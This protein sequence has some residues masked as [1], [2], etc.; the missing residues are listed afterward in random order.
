MSDYSFGWLPDY[1]DMRDRSVTYMEP[2]D[3]PVI[4]PKEKVSVH[5]LWA[6]ASAVSKK[7]AL[8]NLPKKVLIWKNIF[9]Q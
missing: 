8:K 6:K 5:R 2:N 4:D 3:K 1:P 7:A 9:L